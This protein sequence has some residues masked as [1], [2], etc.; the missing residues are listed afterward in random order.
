VALVV[1]AIQGATNNLNCVIGETALKSMAKQTILL[2]S[3]FFAFLTFVVSLVS[4]AVAFLWQ[5]QVNTSA[6]EQQQNKHYQQ[7]FDTLKKVTSAQIMLLQKQ[8]VSVAQRPILSAILVDKN[9]A[10]ITKQQQILLKL[11]P[12]AKKV[13]LIGSEVDNIDKNACI[14]ITYATLESLRQAKQQGRSSISVMQ[15]GTDG[16]HMLLAQRITDQYNNTVGVLA[17]TFSPEIVKNQLFIGENLDGYAEL[18]QGNTS[19]ITLASKG[20]RAS[21]Q[22]AASFRLDLVG[23]RWYISYWPE[24]TSATPPFILITIVFTIMILMWLLREALRGY[25]NKTDVA[26]LKQQL[27]DLNSGEMKT[28]YAIIDPDLEEISDNIKTL[29]STVSLN[30]KAAKTETTSERI[31]KKLGESRTDN[32][33]ELDLLEEHV[34]IDKSIFKAYDIRGIVGESLNVVVVELIGR[35]IGSQAQELGL[36]HIVVGRDG[37]HS[38]PEFS[39]ALITGILASG[40]NVS[41]LGMLPTPVL[42]FAS[43]CL[44]IPSAVMV[45]GSHNPASHNGFK[46]VLAGKALASDDLQALY[47]RV[48]Q[49]NFIVGQGNRHQVDV[50]ETYLQKITEDIP[51]SRPIKVVI[52]CANGVAADFAPILFRALGCEVIELYCDIDGDFPNHNPDPSQPE[53]LQD[54][55]KAVQ[56]HQ[57]E[58][59][60]AFDG[61]G[62]RLG[63]VDTIGNIIFP[64]RLMMMFAQDVLLQMP[65]SVIIYDVK[66]TNLLGEEISR[67]GGEALMLPSDHSVIKNKMIEVDAQL[68]GELSGHIFFKDRWPGFDD[69]MYAAA[70]LLELLCQDPLARTPTEIFAALPNRK[71][72]PEILLAMDA[73]ESKRFITQIQQQGDFADAQITTIDGLRADYVNGWGLVR[74]SNTMSGLTLRFEGD[75]EDDLYQIQEQFKRQMLVIKPTLVLSFSKERS[76]F[77]S[78]ELLHSPINL[79]IDEISS[80]TATLDD[81]ISLSFDEP[82]SAEPEQSLSLTL[83]EKPALTLE[84]IK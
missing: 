53:N 81:S 83:E 51:L 64:D 21:K 68:A 14:P 3:K 59:G 26:T 60:I 25:V 48:F 49:A 39:E 27:F 1:L 28:K 84:D 75:T 2:S 18:Q 82:L 45:T 63:V 38:S 70:R 40:C 43:Y 6:I 42:Y 24:K 57:A 56:E 76:S 13:C 15:A 23:T 41:D 11:F 46:I 29:A 47:L 71:A 79:P 67:A 37:R 30:S 20:D 10:Q 80:A 78:N 69:G 50:M 58:L 22:G 7:T 54:L 36:S 19:L 12:S 61:D 33:V 4:V 8:L 32:P 35:A 62:N 44:D 31:S 74:A 55:I 52:D 73:E 66:S 9:A 5:Y 34:D 72:T 16:A 77:S 65:E 17:L